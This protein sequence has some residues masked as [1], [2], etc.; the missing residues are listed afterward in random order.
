MGGGRFVGWNP[1]T[2]NNKCFFCQILP[3]FYNNHVDTQQCQYWYSPCWLAASL[4]KDTLTHA[5]SAVGMDNMHH[6]C[7]S[8]DQDR[9]VLVFIIIKNIFI[10]VRPCDIS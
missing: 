4:N 7:Y 6:K 3:F 8:H 2:R 5:S 1:R 9:F 10:C